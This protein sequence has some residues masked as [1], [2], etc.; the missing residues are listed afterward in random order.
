MGVRSLGDAL[1]HRF[2]VV[3][4]RWCELEYVPAEWRDSGYRVRA[5][6][7]ASALAVGANQRRMTALTMA[8]RDGVP[9]VD[10][11]RALDVRPDARTIR[12]LWEP[13][14]LG[15]MVRHRQ[16]QGALSPE[17]FES[18]RGSLIAE[19]GPPA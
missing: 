18:I 2:P 7:W 9:I 12:E 8:L 5:L 10:I 1:A 16:G 6:I 15:E 11:A 3:F 13:W 14:A 17:E 19:E 4:Q